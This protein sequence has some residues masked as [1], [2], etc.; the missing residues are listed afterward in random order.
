MKE[1]FHL[2]EGSFNLK[3]TS[4]KIITYGSYHGTIVRTG[5]RYNKIHFYMCDSAC[6]WFIVKKTKIF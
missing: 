3:G 4:I 6:R 5:I 2:K 1:I